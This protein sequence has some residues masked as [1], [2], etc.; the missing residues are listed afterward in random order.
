[1]D[2]VIPSEKYIIL[3]AD[4]IYQ[5]TR[6]DDGL[7]PKTKSLW[8]ALNNA[9]RRGDLEKVKKCVLDVP[10]AERETFLN[11]QLYENWYGTVLHTAAHH[12]HLNS[13]MP[14]PKPFCNDPNAMS[15]T[16]SRIE[17]AKFLMEQGADPSVVDY[18]GDSCHEFTLT[19]KKFS[20]ASPELF[21]V[22]SKFLLSKK[23]KPRSS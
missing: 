12:S 9:V 21:Y 3:R 10:E 20:S 11:I 6:N 16:S 14:N 19:D 15:V 17:V 13:N 4:E 1:M 5:E 18:Y 2:H 7:S 8:R 22:I 23:Y